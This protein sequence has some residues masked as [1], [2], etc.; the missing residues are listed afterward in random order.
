MRLLIY[1]PEKR[2][3]REIN[4]KIME[5]IRVHLPEDLRMNDDEFFRFCQDN[6]ELKFERRRNGDIVFMG[7]TN[8]ETG[9]TNFEIG[10]EFG[11]WNRV[12]QFGKIFDSSSGF[13]LPDTS[14][15]SPDV[16]LI[17]QSRWD[18]LPREQRRKCAPICPDFVLELKSSSDRSKDC[19]EKMDDW[20]ANGC[21]LAWLIDLDTQKTY[22]YRPAQTR[23]ER[24]GLGILSG[25]AVLVGFTL[26]LAQF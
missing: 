14:V 12:A 26:D 6:K 1:K 10:L 24:D 23:E 17:E 5:A 18:A 22:I 21:R 16:S 20:M 4:R 8:S 25:E 7:L 9:N 2:N 15:M 11:N 19:F 13:T 3:L